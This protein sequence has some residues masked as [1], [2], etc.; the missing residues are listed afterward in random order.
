MWMY[1]VE[2]CLRWTCM[3][4]MA[5]WVHTQGFICA[6]KWCRAMRKVWQV[7]LRVLVQIRHGKQLIPWFGDGMTYGLISWYSWFPFCLHFLLPL[8]WLLSTLSLGDKKP[9][10]TSMMY[11]YPYIPNDNVRVDFICF[12]TRSRFDKTIA[13]QPSPSL[14]EVHIYIYIYCQVQDLIIAQVITL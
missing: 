10:K 2:W 6:A 8:W 4:I 11:D 9:C 1:V 13:G 7:H 12:E 5:I 14:D 3:R